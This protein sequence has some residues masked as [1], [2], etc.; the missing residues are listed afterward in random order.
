[1]KQAQL[2]LGL[3]LHDDATFANFY[4]DNNIHLIEALQ[5]LAEGSG[6]HFIYMHGRVGAGRS[7]LL[8]ACCH[9]AN[10]SQR[11]AM[12]LP[13]SDVA[14]SPSILDSIEHIDV[15][16]IDD[17]DAVLGVRKW[18]EALFHCY[19]RIRQTGASLVMA[20]QC[21]PLQLNCILPDLQS[22]LAWG[23]TF[24]VNELA[25]QQRLQALRMRAANRGLHVSDDVGL[26]LLRHYA[27]DTQR[28][29]DALEQLD[30]ASLQAKRRLTIPFV[31]ATLLT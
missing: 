17:I 4:P 2:T 24:V 16:C 28:L 12:Y 5:Q 19:N 29:F 1:M 13:L 9:A 31:K 21:A 23:L 8:Q 27:R 3:R 25:E 26:F 22:R 18:E 14:L 7:H 6:E 11:S 10:A 15:I 30:R 20:A